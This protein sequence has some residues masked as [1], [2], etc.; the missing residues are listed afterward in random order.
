MDGQQPYKSSEQGDIEKLKYQIKDLG[1]LL[2]KFYRKVQEKTNLS[3]IERSITSIDLYCYKS[4]NKPMWCEYNI[5]T[6]LY[7]KDKVTMCYSDMP[8]LPS[9][10]RCNKYSN[11][12]FELF[13]PLQTISFLESIKNKFLDIF[14]VSF[15]G[16]LKNLD[17]QYITINVDIY[18]D[19]NGSIKENPEISKHKIDKDGYKIE[20]EDGIYYIKIIGIIR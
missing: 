4:S 3:K 19:S 16:A 15:P 17:N 9:E 10:I 18:T 2:N 5:R 13:D 7:S 1:D 8:Y 6:H 12:S 11:E 14:D 20:Y